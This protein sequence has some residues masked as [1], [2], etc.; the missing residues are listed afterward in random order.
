MNKNYFLVMVLLCANAIAS[1]IYV[2]KNATGANNGTS[3]TNAYTTIETAFANSIVGDQIWV[4]AGVYKPAGTSRSTTYLIPNG[5]A[6]YG[7]FAGTETALAQRD[8]SGGA[9]TT[10]NGDINTVG[11]Q[12]D[13]CYYVVRFTNAS[14]LTVLDGF[15]IVNGYNN[16]SVYGGAIYN[17]GGQP[18]IRN[19]EMIAN[20]AAKGGAFGN[21]TIDSNVTTLVNCKIRNNSAGEGGGIFNNSGILKLI[22]CDVTSNTANY[23]GGIH[24]EFDQVIIDRT[25][26]SGNSASETGG[27]IYL[28]NAACSTEIYNSLMVGNFANDESVLGMNSAF[29]NP[30]Y[31]K[32]VNCTIANNRNTST[33]A[34]LSFIITLPYNGAAFHN[35]IMTNNT[36]PR[37]LLN[38][39]VVNCIIDMG[40]VPASQTGVTTVAPSFMMANIPA[41]AP[42]AHDGYNY[43][44]NSGSAGINS[45]NNSMVNPLYT[46]DLAGAG[47]IAN[48]T[49]DI[50]AYEFGSLGNGVFEP[51]ATIG[52]YPNPTEG[53]VFLNSIEASLDFTVVS[54]TGSVLRKGTV[55]SGNDAIDLSGLQNGVYIVK[56]S[57]GSNHRIVKK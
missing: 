2:N 41:A 22:N 35:N 1:T 4:A 9:T 6:V 21:S 39:T 40:F 5:V 32:I 25:I 45:G 54:V 50:G 52:F 18:T 36:A 31:S 8:L 20:Y 17:S 55:S 29:S 15:K 46:L 19:C 13:N 53:Q 56:L 27:A 14:S 43:R 7:S 57:D 49:V 11:V 28:D 48:T 42:F 26:L 10:L 37:A 3:W 16:S 34:N 47:R 38:G 44:L 30:E 33:D 24:V 12:T 51:A 23:G